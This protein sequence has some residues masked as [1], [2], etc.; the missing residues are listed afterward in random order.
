[1]RNMKIEINEQQPLDE[2]VEELERLGYKR[3]KRQRRGRVRFVIADSD[4]VTTNW[5]GDTDCDFY[6]PTTLDE[7]KEMKCK[8]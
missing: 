1:M 6:K 7:L 4:G 5:F 2:V 3:N 8:I